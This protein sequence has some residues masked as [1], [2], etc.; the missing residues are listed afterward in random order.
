MRKRVPTLVFAM[1]VVGAGALGAR[2]MVPSIDE[3]M[4]K[5]HN[6]KKG[7]KA[8][9]LAEA[10]KPMPDWSAM[11]RLCKEFTALAEALPKNEPPKGDAAAW[12]KLSKAYVALV[13]EFEQAAAKKDLAALNAANT[14]INKTCAGCHDAHRD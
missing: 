8:L 12:Q 9:V 10:K 3:I 14:K 11:Q 6:A 2:A 7:L 4:T 13:Q 1:L 5:A